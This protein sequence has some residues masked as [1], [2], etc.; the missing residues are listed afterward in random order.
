MCEEGALEEEAEKAHNASV[1]HLTPTRP[2]MLAIELPDGA[3]VTPRAKAKAKPKATPKASF[4]RGHRRYSR[5]A[6]C[7]TID[8]IPEAAR[9]QGELDAAQKNYTIHLKSGAVIEVQLRTKTYRIKKIDGGKPLSD[10]L[11][12]NLCWSKWG[13]PVEAWKIAMERVAGKLE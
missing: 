8:D 12:P 6:P 5:N 1:V 4:N 10:G 11:K 3:T 13:G 7:S 2:N 9:P